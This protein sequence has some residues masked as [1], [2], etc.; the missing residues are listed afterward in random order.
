MSGQVP[1]PRELFFPVLKVL[2]SIPR[3]CIGVRSASGSATGSRLTAEQ[4]A[5]RLPSGQ[6]LKYRH[7]IGWCLT[8]LKNAGLVERPERGT[9]AITPAGLGFL[10][11]HPNGLSREEQ[12]ELARRASKGEAKG[13]D[14]RDVS[15]GVSEEAAQTPEERIDAAVREHHDAVAEELLDA[16]RSASPAFFEDLVLEV[17][18]AAGYGTRRTDLQRVGGSGDGGI[19]GIISLDRLGLEK[20]YVQAKRY[21][22]G[23]TVGRPAIQGF[24][25]ALHGRHAN[26]GVFITSSSFSHEARQY[27]ESVPVNVVLLDGRE[28]AQLMIELGVGVNERRTIH[29]VDFDSDYFSEG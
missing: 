11:E 4:R 15:E 10:D 29:I 23:N 6:S 21:S 13:D 22:A 19:D 16:I 7:R 26:A 27:A 17:L 5:V 12:L 3:G 28:L 14:G 20:V 2:A 1:R 24:V 8:T 9:R 18:H 25:G